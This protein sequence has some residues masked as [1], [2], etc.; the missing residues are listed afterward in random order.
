MSYGNNISSTANVRIGHDIGNAS[1]CYFKGEISEVRVWGFARQASEIS[2]FANKSISGASYGLAGYWRLNEGVGQKGFSLHN[3]TVNHG[4]LG[5]TDGVD[6][7]DPVWVLSNTSIPKKVGSS[8]ER[9]VVIDYWRTYHQSTFNN[10][11][12]NGFDDD[13]GQGID[14]I[15][16]SF[17]VANTSLVTIQ[18][19]N[20]QVIDTY[21]T[22]Y[23]AN[24]AY[25]ESND[26]Y[27]FGERICPAGQANDYYGSIKMNLNPGQ[28]YVV[29]EGFDQT[30]IGNITTTVN[31]DPYNSS[32]GVPRGRKESLTSGTQVAEDAKALDTDLN[33]PYPNPVKDGLLFFGKQAGEYVLID[34]KGLEVM[35]GSNTDRIDARQLTPG[36]YILKTDGKAEKIIVE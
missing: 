12:N 5:S 35:K 19:C 16:Y 27:G 4:R 13:L 10:M 34:G 36:I 11:P 31:I 17:T 6:V 33:R 8:F 7:S 29:V 26:D 22:L 2:S 28:Y 1:N 25:V 21:L 15:V 3:T 23:N 30:Y 18:T 24:R 20:S 9:P 32:Y 14:D